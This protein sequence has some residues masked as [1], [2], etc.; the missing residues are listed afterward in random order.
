MYMLHPH[1]V[2]EK[3]F[4]ALGV[5]ER[6]VTYRAMK[7]VDSVGEGGTWFWWWGIE[8]FEGDVPVAESHN[9]GEHRTHSSDHRHFLSLSL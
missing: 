2:T 3:S 8:G 7:D 4:I 9:L 1:E 5:D 6:R